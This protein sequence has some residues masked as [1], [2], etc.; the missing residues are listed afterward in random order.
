MIFSLLKHVVLVLIVKELLWLL[1]LLEFLKFLQHFVAAA[2]FDGC[3]V[4]ILSPRVLRQVLAGLLMIYI[5]LQLFRIGNDTVLTFASVPAAVIIIFLFLVETCA[6]FWLINLY[7]IIFCNTAIRIIRIL[8]RRCPLSATFIAFVNLFEISYSSLFFT[9]TFF[10]LVN[11]CFTKFKIVI[12]LFNLLI[13]LFEI[14][15]Y[16][17]LL[18][19]GAFLQQAVL[20]A[21]VWDQFFAEAQRLLDIR[22][23]YGVLQRGVAQQYGM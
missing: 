10:T 21:N 22:L 16:F 20:F 9:S 14:W 17:Q 1:E 23:V 3:R 11:M 7:I 4:T 13:V 19:N 12:Y 5:R 15:I 18:K 6:L 8:T 2:A